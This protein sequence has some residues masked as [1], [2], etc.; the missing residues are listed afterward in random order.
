MEL[1]RALNV[2]ES[3]ERQAPSQALAVYELARAA[4]HADLGRWTVLKSGPLATLNQALTTQGMP[5]IAITE[6]ER[7]IDYFMTR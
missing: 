3:S 4:S 7:E 5:P 1:T 2:V 6:I